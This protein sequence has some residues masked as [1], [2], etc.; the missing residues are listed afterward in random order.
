MVTWGTGFRNGD[1]SYPCLVPLLVAKRQF[2][3]M[4]AVK[5]RLPALCVSAVMKG[6]SMSLLHASGQASL[7][8]RSSIL[9]R[10]RLLHVAP[11]RQRSSI[12]C[13]GASILNRESSLHV[14]PARQRSSIA[15][16]GVW[17]SKPFDMRPVRCCRPHHHPMLISAHCMSPFPEMVSAFII[18]VFI[19]QKWFHQVPATSHALYAMY[20]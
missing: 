6:R 7:V 11:A 3:C 4:T 16:A 13:A 15:C 14:A 2:W 8:R 5:H 18:S 17:Y 9:N 12:A 20:Q 1:R 19:I 10:E